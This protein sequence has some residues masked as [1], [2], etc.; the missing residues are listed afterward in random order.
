MIMSEQQDA[1]LK[2]LGL[3][4]VFNPRGSASGIFFS[5]MLEMLIM[6]TNFVVFSNVGK[7]HKAIFAN[8]KSISD[9]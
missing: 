4:C 5:E 3:F 2:T 8:L 1:Q 6:F 7:K 9:V